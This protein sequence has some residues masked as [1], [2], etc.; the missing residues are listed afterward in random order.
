MQEEVDEVSNNDRKV[1]KM[2]YFE[3]PWLNFQR[4]EL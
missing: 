4:L 1:L 2:Y 3:E